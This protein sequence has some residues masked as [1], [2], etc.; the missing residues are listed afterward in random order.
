MVGENGPELVQGPAMVTSAQAT[1][2]RGGSNFATP[3]NNVH[4]NIINASGEK[5]TENRRQ[6]GDKQMIE[7]VIG[8]VR[9]GMAKDIAKG[10]TPLSK[11]IEGTYNLSRGRRS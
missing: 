11:S 4:V 5:V 1:W 8:Q 9:Q 3:Q 6:D 7:F 2:D 10:G